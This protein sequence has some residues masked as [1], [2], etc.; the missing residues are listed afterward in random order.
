MTMKRVLVILTVLTGLVA[1]GYAALYLAYGG[2]ARGVI[3]DGRRMAAWRADGG[4]ISLDTCRYML[5]VPADIDLPETPAF[6]TT[7]VRTETCKYH[8][9]HFPNWGTGTTY[10]ISGNGVE[11]EVGFVTDEAEKQWLDI[12]D[13]PVG[14][15]N[16][17]LLACGN[18]GSFTIT[19]K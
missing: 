1:V 14:S 19:V 2:F 7:F 4:S 18:G 5:K 9:V 8:L 3:E 16:V 13:L 12:T 17:N 10:K 11:R 6:D 15:Y